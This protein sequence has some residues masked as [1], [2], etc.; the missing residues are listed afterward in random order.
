MA[1]ENISQVFRLKNVDE[2]RTCFVE[3]IEQN[4]L[5]SKKHKKV[6]MTIN[7][8]KRSLILASTTTGRITIPEFASLVSMSIGIASS[9]ME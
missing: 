5:M 7:Y 3:E 8:I 9:V 2:T 4:E 1:D 6:S